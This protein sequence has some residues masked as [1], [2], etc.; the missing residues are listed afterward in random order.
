MTRPD[1]E[2]ATAS[3]IGE[4]GNGLIGLDPQACTVCMIC[5]R[6][7]PDWCI[8][9]EGHEE[10]VQPASGGRSRVVKVLDRFAIDFG[11][12]MFC[13]ICIEVCPYDALAWSTEREV[14]ATT[15]A[16]LVHERER[17]ETW[18]PESAPQDGP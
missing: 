11:L 16:G 9:I 5:A 17:L 15:A 1:A 4:Q 10:R 18:W 8:H 12:C 2:P 13:G 7:C 3:G 6:E 14:S